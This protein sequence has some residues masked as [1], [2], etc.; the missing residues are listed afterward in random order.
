MNV[1]HGIGS[2]RFHH[3]PASARQSKRSC[4]RACL[5][6]SLIVISGRPPSNVRPFYLGRRCSPSIARTK[7]N[8]TDWALPYESSRLMTHPTPESHSK[9]RRAGWKCLWGLYLLSN[10]VSISGEGG[11]ATLLEKLS[12][13]KSICSCVSHSWNFKPV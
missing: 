8:S 10:R 3:A 11:N 12:L 4:A 7:Q 9:F 13:P 6:M 2:L 1:E 5:A